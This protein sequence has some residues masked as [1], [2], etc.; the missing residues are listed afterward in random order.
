MQAQRHGAS[1]FIHL[2]LAV[3]MILALCV[4]PAAASEDIVAGRVFLTFDDGPINI[5]LDILDELKLRHV[6]ATFF[7]NAIH[8]DGQG[9]E[10]EDRAKEALRRI[11]EEGHVIGNHS[12]DHMGHN[13][14]VG[15]YASAAAKAYRDVGT[16]LPYFIPMNVTPVNDALGELAAWPN[17]RISTLARLPFANVWAFPEMGAVCA[18]C[19]AS[20]SA[21]WHPDAQARADREASEAGGQLADVLQK[22]YK[23]SSFGWDIQWMPTDWASPAS[24]ETLPPVAL[25]E[26]EVVALLDGGRYCVQTPQGEHCKSPLRS[27]NVILLAH[28]FLFENGLRGRGKDINM[29]Q[30]IKLIGA[31]RAKGYLFETMDHYLD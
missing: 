23:I 4:L 11:V 15:V 31:L 3:G 9:G 21:F 19:G 18:W 16:D 28:D 7:I 2:S 8:L 26:R 20:S 12:Y 29:P 5:T 27:K 17:N 24:N 22:R 13:R 10:N 14:P 1:L 30:L 25:I 6:K